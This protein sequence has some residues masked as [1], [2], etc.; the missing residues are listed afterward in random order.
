MAKILIAGCGDLGYR[1][2]TSLVE[3][4]HR[5]GAIKRSP[6]QDQRIDW[7]AMDLRDSSAWPT[8]D[9]D[10]DALFYLP[11]PSERSE[12][13]YRDIFV[14]GL[15]NLLQVIPNTLQRGWC[16]FISSTAVYGQTG[17]E[18]VDETSATEPK[19]YNGRVLLEAEQL[20]LTSAANSCSVRLAGIYGPG[21]ERLI[22][23][24][25]SGE[26]VQQHPPS[27]TNR[28]HCD[29]A[30]RL[31]HFLLDQYLANRPLEHCYIGVDSAPASSWE[32]H[33]WLAQQLGVTLEASTD[34]YENQNKRCSNQRILAAG[35]EFLYPSFKEGY[36]AMLGQS[37]S[38]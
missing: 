35:F 27:Y 28:I 2:A 11:T 5:V 13:G 6:L 7:L 14:T 20:I 18:W 21:R 19:G 26:P 16:C 31:L 24:V 34:A 8:L 12:A 30:A 4:G 17:G 25:Q 29:D 15:S 32:V 37:P 36:G 22:R 1:L 3:Q 38:A 33:S 9:D 23:M 10:F